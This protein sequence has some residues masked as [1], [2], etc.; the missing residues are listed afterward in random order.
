ML[1]ALYCLQKL[2]GDF[3]LLEIFNENNFK[4]TR[5]FFTEKSQN[6]F[7]HSIDFKGHTEK[8]YAF[9]L[10]EIWIYKDNVS[11]CFEYVNRLC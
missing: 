6:L 10:E 2:A 1:Y 7:I 9:S 8:K 4:I 3:I 11:P 5:V